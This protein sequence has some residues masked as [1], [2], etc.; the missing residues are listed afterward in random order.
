[1]SEL[2]KPDPLDVR[3]RDSSL[4]GVSHVSHWRVSHATVRQLAAAF[5]ASFAGNE[6]LCSLFSRR[7]GVQARI[8]F[9]RAVAGVASACRVRSSTTAPD[10]IRD[11]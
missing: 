4:D 10:N 5:T 11:M 1:M 9:S 3:V 7:A 2:E 8:A 6:L